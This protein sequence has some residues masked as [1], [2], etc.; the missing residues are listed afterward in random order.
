M[1]AEG[2]P[3]RAGGWA[4]R[5]GALRLTATLLLTALMFVGLS[6]RS[7]AGD[8]QSSRFDG[9][10]RRRIE[11][12]QPSHVLLG[13]SMM[14]SRIDEQ[15]LA[16]ALGRRVSKVWYGGAASAGWY[17][18][19]KNQIVAAKHRPDTVTLFFRDDMLV[20]PQF[21][22]T[23]RYGRLLERQADGPNR[24]FDRILAGKSVDRRGAA[25]AWFASATGADELH[26]AAEAQVQLLANRLAGALTNP[27]DVEARRSKVRD[28]FAGEQSEDEDR[29]GEISGEDWGESVA[30]EQSF[31]PPIVR[32]TE[33]AGIRLNLVRVQRSA[34]NRKLQTKQQ[35]AMVMQHLV[36]LRRFCAEHGVTFVDLNGSDWIL[37]DWYQGRG[38][39]IRTKRRAAY[40]KA[41]VRH[42]RSLFGQTAPTRKRKVGAP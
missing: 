15:T 2:R 32:L 21:R 13:N 3:R 41:F 40:T 5:E 16:K 4:H 28:A 24:G 20:R 10:T 42:Q 25:W 33:E 36:E 17:L 9:S 19:L 14:D 39:H 35:N 34:H 27:L 31:L 11:R 29:E 37:P 30:L 12:E 1:D 8:G 22:T 18:M 26:R 6:L 7:T 38:D 23:G